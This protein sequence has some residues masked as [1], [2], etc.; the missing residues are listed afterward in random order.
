VKFETIMVAVGREFTVR[1]KSDSR[2]GYFWRVD[3]LVEGVEF[4]G[5]CLERKGDSFSQGE[6]VIH[7]FRF[8]ATAAGEYTIKFILK[9]QREGDPTQV[10]TVAVIAS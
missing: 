1:L 2:T 9:T 4:L 6:K 8:C 7:L 5:S 3:P 10:H